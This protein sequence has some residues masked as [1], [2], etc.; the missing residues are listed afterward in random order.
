MILFG[1]YPVK[2]DL[3]DEGRKSAEPEYSPEWTR[4]WHVWEEIYDERHEGNQFCDDS[5][6]D[7]CG[8]RAMGD[9]W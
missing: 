3:Y 1:P 8:H 9:D 6:C 5:S 2:R 4:L 7:E